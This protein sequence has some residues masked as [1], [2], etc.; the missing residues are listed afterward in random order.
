MQTM[1]PIRLSPSWPVRLAAPI[2]SR[3]ASVGVVRVR[4][5][6]YEDPVAS[7][8]L[9]QLARMAGLS[10]Y[11]FLRVFASAFGLS[12]HAL[13]MR[14]RLE[15]AR[16]FIDEGRS[17]VFVAYDAGFADQSHLTRRFKRCF[18]VTPG[19]Y[20]HLGGAATLTQS[21]GLGGRVGFS[22]LAGGDPV[23]KGA[24]MFRPSAQ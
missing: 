8:T 20:R 13:Q 19:E 24:P 2:S 1:M 4:E 6:L 10:K 5:Y 23:G 3:M 11:H 14:L 12:P 15:L 21:S 17:L 18:G 7:I 16:R 9:D 22:G